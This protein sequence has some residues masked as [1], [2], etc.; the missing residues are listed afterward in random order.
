MLVGLYLG[1]ILACRWK[2][3]SILDSYKRKYSLVPSKSERPFN[4]D[5]MPESK[6]DTYLDS[7][8][9]SADSE[10]ESDIR[11]SKPIIFQ[12]GIKPREIKHLMKV[13]IEYMAITK[14][15]LLTELTRRE[16]MCY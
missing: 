11:R 6:V 16:K 15:R 12:I 13:K 4:E 10:L 7:L 14:H 5:V 9:C 2:T 1:S 8:P 3:G